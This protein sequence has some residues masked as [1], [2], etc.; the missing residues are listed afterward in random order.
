MSWR[1]LAAGALL[2]AVAMVRAGQ[3]VRAQT[4]AELSAA[5]TLSGGNA[6]SCAAAALASRAVMGHVGL[7]SGLGSEVSG[8]ATTLGTRIGGGPRLAFSG[9]FAA[10]RMGA[11]STST[12][13]GPDDAS[14]TGTAWHAGVALGVFEGVRLMP[15]VGGVLSVDLFAHLAL[16]GLPEA[17]FSSGV[18][19]FTGGVRVGV[20]REGF[21]I[22]GVSISASKRF[23]GD[24]VYGAPSAPLS[25]TVDP[26]VTSLRATVGKDL[27]AVELMAG[28]GWDEYTGD[29][30]LRVASGFGGTTTTTGDMSGSR[31]LYFASASRTFSILL[32]LAVE[33]GWAAGFD[34]LAAYTGAYDP[35]ARTF[36][37]GLAA[38]LTL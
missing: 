5:C 1:V 37:G 4:P 11:P 20:F 30:T 8:S 14:F 6:S 35:G 28:V 2:G 29:T 13:G 15:T 38:R 17:G 31:R 24:V 19:A 7:L 25:T 10:A 9:R 36:F 18:T 26:S 34:P 3:P 23:V 21:T 27:H 12:P 16:L 22:P 32:T 33:A